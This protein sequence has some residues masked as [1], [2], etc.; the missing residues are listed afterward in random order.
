MT[1]LTDLPLAAFDLE[2]TGVDVTA[3]RIVTA[4]I[5][6][7]DGAQVHTDEWLLNPEIEIPTGA[8]DVHGV[9]TERARA[10]GQD[11][12]TGYL[13]IRNRL[14]TLWAQGRLVAIMN[15]EFDLSIIDT[16][17]HRLGRPPLTV[18]A[19]FDPFVVDRAI[20]PYRRGKRTLDA[21]CTHYGV[22]QDDAHQATGDALAAA[23]LAYVLRQR[24]EFADYDVDALMSAQAVWHHDRQESYRQWLLDQDRADDAAGVNTA[25]PLALKETA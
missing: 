1:P 20:D 11:Y 15:A 21:L 17:G 16:E 22:R 4:S 5:C 23:R 2:T 3:D 24:T 13:E 9:T 14:E 19:V 25:W 6:V 18:G 7:I 8:S 12:A 10:E